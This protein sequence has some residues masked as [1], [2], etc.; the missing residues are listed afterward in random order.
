MLQDY[1]QIPRARKPHPK[2]KFTPQEDEKLRELVAAFGDSDWQ[3]ISSEMVTRS[4][5]QCR[6][7]WVTY[8]SPNVIMGNWTDKEDDLLIQLQR[9]FGSHWKLIAS[10]FPNRTDVALRN[11]FSVLKRREAKNL[12]RSPSLPNTTVPDEGN[13][14]KVEE[15]EQEESFNGILNAETELKTPVQSWET[16]QSAVYSW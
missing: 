1:N 16:E 11:R 13:S 10:W 9:D 2:S 7:R 14:S 12:R 6:E 15:V 5:R 8:L 4:P 3:K